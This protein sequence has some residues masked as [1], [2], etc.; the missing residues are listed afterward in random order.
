MSNKLLP[1]LG[2]LILANAFL[3]TNN[4]CILFWCDTDMHFEV[5]FQPSYRYEVS[6]SNSVDAYLTV[7]L[8]DVVNNRLQ[9]C[10]FV[11]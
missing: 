1:W 11:L 6:F 9:K 5:S 2:F 3:K 8:M 10:V 7:R 4:V